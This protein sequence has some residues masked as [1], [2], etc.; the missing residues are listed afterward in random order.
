MRLCDVIEYLVVYEVDLQEADKKHIIKSYGQEEWVRFA[1]V[2]LRGIGKQHQVPG[3]QVRQLWDICDQAQGQALV[4]EQLWL[5]FHIIWQNWHN[6]G[7][8]MRAS[9]VL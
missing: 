6:L 9:L 2:F 5:M 1:Q 8:E 7:C 4:Y 3:K